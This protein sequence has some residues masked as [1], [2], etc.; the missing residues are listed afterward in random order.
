M[1][2]NHNKI[3]KEEEK[4]LIFVY[5]HFRHGSRSP[6]Y[7]D[8]KFEDYFGLKW[9]NQYELL[10]TGE[11]MHYIIGIHNRFRYINELKFLSSKFDAHEIFVIPTCI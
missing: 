11:R 6:N 5:S 9:D 1:I 8:S 2:N 3:N 7:I 10:S 4:K